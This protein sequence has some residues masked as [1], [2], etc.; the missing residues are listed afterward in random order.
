MFYNNVNNLNMD[1]LDINDVDI[2]DF[3]DLL[4]EKQSTSPSKSENQKIKKDDNT[5]EN[6]DSDNFETDTSNGRIIC[7]DCGYVNNE[8]LDKNLNN[9]GDKTVSRYGCP[10]NFFLPMSSLGTKTHNGRNT[11]IALLEKWSQMPY[12]ERSLLDVLQDIEKNCKKHNIPAS[13][14]ENAKILFKRVN[15]LKTEADKNKHII[16]RGLNRRSIIA[17]CVFH[18]ASVQNMPRS[19]KEIATIFNIEEKQV[20]KGC[21]KLRDLLPF[22]NILSELKSSQSY[23]FI[24]RAEYSKELGLTENN[25]KIAKKISLNIKKLGIA[26][27]HQ[28]PSVAAGA[29]LLLSE[30]LGLNINKKKISKTFRISQVTIMKTYKKIF[31]YRKVV[32]SDENTN[33]LLEII[34]D[35]S[36]ENKTLAKQEEKPKKATKKSTPKKMSKK[37]T[38]KKMLKKLTPKVKKE[39]KKTP[40]VQ[41]QQLRPKKAILEPSNKSANSE[42]IIDIESDSEED[43]IGSINSEDYEE[44]DDLNDENSVIKVVD[45]EEA[46]PCKN[47]ISRYL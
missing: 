6:C 39:K 18:G 20:T 13:I 25:I 27:D 28:P 43:Q 12:K 45:N 47:L 2:L 9:L 14:I 3:I 7:I 26:S 41:C 35:N 32:L 37:S 10:T 24:S 15:D 46:Q 42:Q 21:R 33:K 23:N 30:I 40:K 36:S 31:P 19:P 8:L 17:A 4:D 29:I 5:C 22:D 1:D 34:G 16:I 44:S 38:P 11:T